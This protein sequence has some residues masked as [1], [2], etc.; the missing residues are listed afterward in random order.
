MG[1]TRVIGIDTG[2]E[3]R[4]E[5]YNVS[6]VLPFEWVC[7]ERTANG[8]D[9]WVRKVLTLEGLVVNKHKS[10]HNFTP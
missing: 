5:V 1:F 7:L 10:K 6:A 8:G 4:S 2:E 9:Q 3:E